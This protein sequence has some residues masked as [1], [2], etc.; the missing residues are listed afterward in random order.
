M[1][2]QYFDAETGLHYNYHRYYD[3]TTG[4]Y[5]TADPIGLAGGINLF[6]YAY[7]NPINFI[8]PY[9]LDAGVISVPVTMIALGKAI[10]YVGSAAGAAGIIHWLMDDDEDAAEKP[11]PNID[12]G[13]SCP[14][15]PDD[16][17][18]K[19]G[20]IR[21]GKPDVPEGSKQVGETVTRRTNSPAFRDY[22]NRHNI[23]KKGWQ[24]KMQ[25]YRTPDGRMI[26]RH[27]WQQKK[28]GLRFHHLR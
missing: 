21:E 3:P 7:N 4:R 22:L 26:K 5:L 20:G 9:G 12:P 1:A 28:T 24:Y 16:D 23:S 2:G 10:V 13:G 11:E 19:D 25:K 17:D 14:N 8:D 18:P 15:G 6:A 27:W